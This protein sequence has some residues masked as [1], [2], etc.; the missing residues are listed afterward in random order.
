MT[1]ILMGMVNSKAEAD[2]DL[3]VKIRKL[4]GNVLSVEKWVII[5]MNVQGQRKVR[6][7]I[8]TINSSLL[9]I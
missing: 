3:K 4:E 7:T 6:A 9:Q 5:K 2:L 8:I 1:K